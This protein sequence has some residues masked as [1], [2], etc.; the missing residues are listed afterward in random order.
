[1]AATVTEGASVELQDYIRVF[2]KNWW[3][4]ALSVVLAG[5]VAVVYSA[6]ATPSYNATAK[7]FVSTTGDASVSDLAQGNSFAVQRVKTYADLVTT[8]AVLQPAIDELRIGTSVAKLRPNVSASTPLNTTVIDIAV[9]SQDP[10]FAASLATAVAEQL[11]VVVED[12]ETTNTLNGSPVRLTIVQ[13]AEVPTVP[14]S[15]NPTLNLALGLLV[16]MAVGAGAALLRETLNTTIHGERDIELLTHLPVLGGITFDPKAKDRPLILHADPRSVRAE[17]FRTLRTN[18]QFLDADR[19]E[20]AF[21]VTSSVASEGKSTTAANLAIALADSGARVLLVD[22]DLRKPKM[23]QY[24]AVEGGAGLTD[25]LVGRA[26]LADVVQQWGRTRL[27]LLPAGSIPPNP[28]ELVGSARMTDLIAQLN[29]R[30]DVVLFDTP[31]LLPVTDAA[32]LSRL[33]GGSLVVVAA[34]KATTNQ[35]SSALMSLEQV[36]APVS[37]IILT[38]LP[39]RGPNAYGYGRYGYAYSAKDAPAD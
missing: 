27:F 32:I 24:M 1:M 33:V 22:A 26:K 30:Y 7:V 16:G 20:R 6:T 11:T 13:E 36:G 21:V 19:P 38:M 34:G 2:R 17:S 5:A 28:S 15:P 3:I 10:V 25:V 12:I 14:S 4:V 35:L 9:T 29:D 31:P 18:V 23:A 37:G 8:A 39:A